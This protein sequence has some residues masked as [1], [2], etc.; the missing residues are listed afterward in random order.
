MSATL[1]DYGLSDLPA[2][3]ASIEPYSSLKDMHITGPRVIKSRKSKKVTSDK[4]DDSDKRSFG[5]KWFT[6]PGFPP[7]PASRHTKA[8]P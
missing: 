7:K 1:S 4:L 8:S 3:S 5:T 2:Q 6:L